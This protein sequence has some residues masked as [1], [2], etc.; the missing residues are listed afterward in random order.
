MSR[1]IRRTMTRPQALTRPNLWLFL[2]GFGVLGVLIAL[3]LTGCGTP[4]APSAAPAAPTLIP[5]TPTVV[6]PTATPRPTATT[7]PTSPPTNTPVPT[8]SAT[9]APT[10]T[11]T[12]SATAT[13]IPSDTPLPTGTA[14]ATPH[15]RWTSTPVPPP[16]AVLI[17]QGT[18][19]GKMVAL[20]FDCGADRGNAPAILDYLRQQGIAATFG[21]TGRWAEQNPD[22]IR[23]MVD[24]GQQIVNHTY[25]HQSFTGLSMHA[26]PLNK[27]QIA[28]ELERADAILRHLTGSSTR[29][30]YRP[31]YG[32]ESPDTLKAV[33]AAG[34]N[35]DVRWTL[36]SLGWDGLSAQ[37]IE[38]RVL[39]NAAP[40]G[41]I[42]MHVGAASQDAVALPRV[43][44]ALRARGY[45]FASIAG[46]LAADHSP[47]A[48]HPAAPASYRGV[49]PDAVYYPGTTPGPLADR[50]VLLDPGH[51]GDDPGT[52]YPY[53]YNCFASGNPGDAPILNEKT[54]TLDLALYH[55]LPRLHLLGADVYLTRTTGAQNPDLEQRLQLANYVGRLSGDRKRALF[56]SVHLNGAGDPAVDYSQALYARRRPTALASTLDA[57]V[58][59]AL[60]PAPGG[61]DHGIDTFPGHVLRRNKLPATIVE[62]AFLTNVYP[63][64]VPISVTRIVTATSGAALR[65][66]LRLADPVVHVAVRRG[67][68]RHVV[69]L[70]L[71]EA[72]SGTVPLRDA[73][74]VART[75]AISA[76][77]S[78]TMTA[79]ISTAVPPLPVTPIS[80]SAP[81]TL[82]VAALGAAPPI[83]PAL[84]Y[85]ISVSGEV[86][87]TDVMTTFE[88]EGPWLLKAHAATRQANQDYGAPAPA[89]LPLR[90]AWTDREESIA[91][92][93]T[94]GI[95]R[96]FNVRLPP[97]ALRPRETPVA[98]DP[99]VPPAGN[100]LP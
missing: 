13:P 66:G 72:F 61:G 33:A 5:P 82:D 88:G 75:V 9:T 19:R 68:G 41:I 100:M 20:T 1:S 70:S 90:Y 65:Q 51:G 18:A 94:Q 31:P 48:P 85:A 21:V 17:S 44:T 91:R 73:I 71:Q 78:P 27:E 2:C 69:N 32:D 62:P 3:L 16:T 14:T 57:A 40:G 38:A 63:V 52:C 64:Q 34:Y 80:M 60:Q 81:P 67:R 35:V 83:S 55:L 49:D 25:D 36:D 79:L 77:V 22:L 24:E 45:R 37:R 42:L 89:L 97:D 59:R 47:G 53:V 29:P 8:D 10:A 84:T 93:L 58:V 50:V 56:I 92:A 87:A 95:A 4:G 43:V 12:A 28:S 11:A 46:L 26:F 98:L 6:P 15:P 99:V 7:Q 74:T 86:S 39:D 96:F 54:V 30:Y 23:R 76:A